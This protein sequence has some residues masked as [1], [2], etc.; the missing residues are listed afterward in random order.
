VLALLLV[1]LFARFGQTG[2]A[3]GGV[4]SA[5]Y[6]VLGLAAGAFLTSVVAVVAAHLGRNSSV[7]LVDAARV[8]LD[9]ALT[10]A[11]HAGGAAGLAV[12]CVSG[13]GLA[14]FAGVL[15]A[16]QGGLGVAGRVDEYLVVR[17]SLLLPTFALGAAVAAFAW[18]R[19]GAIFHAASDLGADLGGEQRAGLEHDDGRNPALVADLVGDHVGPGVGRSVDMFA[20]V[21][22]ANVLTVIVGVAWAATS[23]SSNARSLLAL[24][25]VVRA[26]G[27]IGSAAGLM[28]VRTNDDARPITALWRGQITSAVVTLAGLAGA[29]VWLVRNHWWRFLVAG[30]LGLGAALAVG[31]SLRYLVGRRFP[32]LRDL[33]EAERVAE[34]ASMAQAI[35][36][37]LERLMP[38]V[39]VM[40]PALTLA[41]GVGTGMDI[42]GGGAVTLTVAL[43]SMLA[44]SPYLLATCTVGS[45]ADSARGVLGLVSGP[46]SD[47]VARRTSAMD[48]AAWVGSS[49]SQSSLGVASATAALLTASA[50]PL[51]AGGAVISW[52]KAEI[53]LSHPVVMW[54]GV[55]GV[56]LLLGYVGSA[57]RAA[58]RAAR[59]VLLEVERQ[60]RG[61]PREREASSVPADFTP[62]Y[63]L[64]IELAN[65]LAPVGLA[66]S[67]G[68]VLLVPAA[69]G[70]GL[71]GLP[72]VDGPA[73]A[74]ASL[75]AFVAG[76]AVAGMCLAWVSEGAR[77]VLGTARRLHHRPHLA[78][79]QAPSNSLP[80]A[81]TGD[82]WADLLGNVAA[83]AAQLVVKTSALA[84]LV[85]AL[86]IH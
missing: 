48:E 49:V 21:T 30:A 25:F 61:F 27:V 50:V 81:L 72:S 43:M 47:E 73:L 41:W 8:H 86:F 78:H 44:L 6:G 83:P 60:L 62:S 84:A 10:V 13:L 74:R 66:G 31:H 42:K 79:P 37:G 22:M 51:V 77:A 3:L 2:S 53:D 20:S 56:A 29:S 59:L 57:L 67:I 15:F 18:Q 35:G 11:V 55:F 7:R 24:P 36:A 4:E 19:T 82:A 71:L 14:A 12:Q 76:T 70:L 52:G 54:S 17:V 80:A 75:V 40:A 26:F 63:R 45:I 34:A 68:A 64:C 69:L 85:M 46:T 16:L 5:I 28:V 32:P 1:G 39:L 58:A 33:V 38:P 23:S 9:R 65:R